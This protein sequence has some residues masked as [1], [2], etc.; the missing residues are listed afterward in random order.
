[1]VGSA[2]VCELSCSVPFVLSGG[3]LFYPYVIIR[4]PESGSMVRASVCKKRGALHVRVAV[5]LRLRTLSARRGRHSDRFF[6]LVP[7]GGDA[8]SLELR[9]IFSQCFP[10]GSDRLV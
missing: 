7:S 9:S 3:V 4:E 8:F 2:C 6:Q 1:M 5:A 10:I